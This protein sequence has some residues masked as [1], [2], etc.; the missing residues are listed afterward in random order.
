MI[1][2][3]PRVV[4]M[5]GELVVGDASGRE[6]VTRLTKN[7]GERRYH[8]IDVEQFERDG[9]IKPSCDHNAHPANARYRLRLRHDLDGIWSGCEFNECYGSYIHGMDTSKERQLATMLENM[10]VE[11]FDRAVAEARGGN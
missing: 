11:E 3:E 4:R 8:R 7:S 9:D 2:G 5:D 6:L 10:S 1:R